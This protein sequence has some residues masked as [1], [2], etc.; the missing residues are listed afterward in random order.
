MASISFDPAQDFAPGEVLSVT[1]PTVVQGSSGVGTARHG[2]QFTAAGGTGP[3]TFGGGSY[4]P[5]STQPARVLA[6]DLDNDGDLD[7]IATAR[8]TDK[9]TVA[10][11]NGSGS[12][13]PLPHVTVLANPYGLAVGDVDNDGDLDAVLCCA[14]ANSSGYVGVVLRNNG[15]GSFV[16][17]GTFALGLRPIDIALGDLDNDGDLDVAS[18]NTS[19]STVSLRFNDGSGTF[20]PGTELPMGAA[21]AVALADADSDGDLDLLALGTASNGSLFLRRNDG[22]G[23]FGAIA[24][25]AIPSYATSLV[26]GDVDADGD[27]D[28]V[29]TH[30][31]SVGL[32]GLSRN[33][34]AVLLNTG[35]GSFA[36]AGEVAVGTFPQRA[37]LGDVDGDGDLDLA[38]A[39]SGTSLVS[40]RLNNGAGTFGGGS[41]VSA[42]AAPEDVD[43]ADLDGDGD[44]DLLIAMPDV[45]LAAVRFNTVLPAL[46]GLSPA[47]G[48]VGTVVQLTGSNLGGATRVTFNGVPATTFTAGAALLTA[49]VPAGAA[50]GLVQVTTPGGTATTPQ[51]FTVTVPGPVLLASTPARNQLAAPAATNVSLSFSQAITAASAANLRVLGNQRRGRRPGTLSGGGS[52]TLSF[53]PSQDFAPG[54]EVSVT[55]PATLQ[56]SA[57]AAAQVLQFTAAAGVGPGTFGPGPDVPVDYDP[58][59]VRAADV[60]NDG[61]AD[62]LVSTMLP[63]TNEYG[64]SLRLND[65][66]GNFSNGPYIITQFGPLIPLAGD[67][68]GDGDLDVVTAHYWNS[69]PA[70]INV[71]LNNGTGTFGG[72][73]NLSLGAMIR[74]AALGDLDADGDLDIMVSTYSGGEGRLVVCRNNGA[75][76]FA[77]LSPALALGLGSGAG[78]LALGDVDGDGDL[79]VATVMRQNSVVLALN[80]GQAAFALLREVPVGDGPSA[81]LLRDLDGDRDL[82]L[83]TSN[84]TSSTISIRFNNGTGL[85][86]GGQD[87]LGSY[88][89]DYNEPAL[90]D[91]D[92]DGDL[93]LVQARQSTNQGQISLYLNN[94]R[95]TFGLRQVVNVVGSARSPVLADFNGDGALDLASAGNGMSA[96]T[97]AN[98]VSIRFNQLVPL[99]DLVIS[100]PLTVAGGSYNNVTVTAT[101]VGTLTGPLDVAG[102]LVVQSGGIFNTNCQPLTGSGNFVLA[103]GAE[104][105]ICDPA[106]IS[107]SGPTGAIQLTGTRSFSPDASY[108]YNG[109]QAQVTGLGLPAQVRNLTVDNDSSGLSLSQGVAVAQVLRLSDGDLGVGGMPLT[110]LSSAQGT[111]LVDNRGGVVQ[112]L[113]SVQRWLA[114]GSNP[115]AGY[116]H[117]ASPIADASVN[118]LTAP[119]FRPTLNPAYNS[120]ATPG[121]VTP[122]PTVYGYDESRLASSPAT[123]MS[124]FDRGWVS[125]GQL[126]DALTVGRGYTVHVAGN[127]TLRF[128]GPLNNG[129]VSCSL[130]RSATPAAE[131]GW[132]LLG[133]PYPSPLDWSRLSIPA[134]LDDALY[135]YRSTG[136]YAGTF[137]SYVNGLGGSP[138]VAL[139]QGFFVRA[140]AAGSPATLTFTNA[141]RITTFGPGQNF[142]RNPADTR[143]VVQ[144]ALRGP[145]G[146]ADDLAYV[147]F[148]AGATAGPDAHYDAE[149]LRNPGASLQLA[150]LAPASSTEQAICGLPPLLGQACTVPLLVAVP[151]PG[152]YAL[153]AEQMANFAVGTTV[154]LHDAQR[155]T[156]QALMAGSTYSFT[157][158]GTTAPGRFRLEFAPAQLT[159]TAAEARAA[160]LSVYPNPATGRFTVQLPAGES[161]SAAVDLTLVNSLGQTVRTLTGRTA[162]SG[163]R[164]EVDASGLAAGVY[165]LRVGVAGQPPLVKRVVLQ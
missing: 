94:G 7:F 125:P 37:T 56:G 152:S 110:L 155:G 107:L 138:E 20:R 90:G 117:L 151:Q 63:S 48:P 26:V 135:V 99:Q 161:P 106:G 77:I 97:A 13:T 38:V 1:V 50:T 29:T 64:L 4:V 69:D 119:G 120:S 14:T 89:Y 58:K 72:G 73:Q 103:A 61:D 39:N 49:T 128:T 79:D 53:D 154:Y 156:R 40:V 2:Y 115:G 3:G 9:V 126:S 140:N 130:G 83:L 148:E 160:L 114:P 104:L 129:P 47:A 44:L 52:A 121:A 118:T 81:V 31:T 66:L 164:A 30:A 116:R 144:L 91:V 146:L 165:S 27:L 88:D 62:L 127:Q 10:L 24:I 6:A 76:T 36:P 142:S 78:P 18:A 80:N 132:H 137:R 95:G 55:L 147:Y 93:D 150:A 23:S 54:E 98:V 96:S 22:Y 5:L 157:L 143:P 133:N 102:A 84:V 124:Y 45:H 105:G 158:A 86:G 34:A 112:G 65:G 75:G 8:G 57:P 19:A 136:A 100:T 139:G 87:M 109:S 68:D 41:E 82:D 32:P 11:N 21:D 51:L 74:S 141:A 15:S 111:A 153:A 85:F 42:G 46:S 101:G 25:S 12:F 16:L 131:T 149:K 122:F 163:F 70:V 60:D 28:V 113:A 145:A 92:G 59:S 35:S 134:G 33:T 162:A 17:A 67:V 108:T 71:R 159:A 43:L 123:G